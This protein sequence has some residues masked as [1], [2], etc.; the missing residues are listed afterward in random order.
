MALDM[1][2]VDPSP[3]PVYQAIAEKARRLDALGLSHERIGAK[4]G[5]SGKTVTKA[6][7]W[8]RSLADGEG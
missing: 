2:L 7:R 8:H 1:V 6:I 5:V 3:L 4:L